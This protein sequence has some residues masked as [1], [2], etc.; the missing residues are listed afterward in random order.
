MAHR[1][2]VYDLDLTGLL[3]HRIPDFSA[4]T[5]VASLRLCDNRL[6]RLDAERLPRG[7]RAL[8]IS[9]NYLAA[10]AGVEALPHLESLYVTHNRL[11][12]LEGA[13]WPAT[14]RVLSLAHNPLTRLP[15]AQLPAQLE[16]LALND[17]RVSELGPLPP[18]LRVL[19]A[20]FTGLRG[21]PSR[22][23][24]ALAHLDLEGC[25]LTTAGLPMRWDSC[26]VLAHVDLTGNRLTALPAALLRLPS[27][28][29]LLASH[30]RLTELDVRGA[31]PSLRVVDVSHNRLR[32]LRG[33]PAAPLDVLRVH[34]NQ[35]VGMPDEFERMHMHMVQGDNAE[36]PP[37][38]AHR[39]IAHANWSNA[40]FD[41][42]AN[43]VLRAWRRHVARLRLRVWLRTQRLRA[44]LVAAAMHPERVGKFEPAGAWLTT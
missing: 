34:N 35:L 43:V 30:N 13:A 27:L 37:L 33:P 23:P 29:T 32:E 42:W 39:I 26:T 12:D 36:P 9:D 17:T 19:R 44:S 14:L 2:T 6:V 41:T 3:T 16:E 22:L 20:A 5:P 40:T 25:K 10:L 24:A 18:S 8:D 21:L 1:L 11:D 28:T 7:L 15:T 31:S 4:R 38:W